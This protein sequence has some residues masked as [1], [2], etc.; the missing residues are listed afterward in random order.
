MSPVFLFG[1]GV[2]RFGS[3]VLENVGSFA[4]TKGAWMHRLLALSLLETNDGTPSP[5]TLGL[6]PRV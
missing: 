6:V 1:L 3:G 5:V 4:L 2:V